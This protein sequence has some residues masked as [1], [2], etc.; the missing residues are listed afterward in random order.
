MY[1]YKRTLHV[2]DF[3][4][5]QTNIVSLFFSQQR[6]LIAFTVKPVLVNFSK[7]FYKSKSEKENVEMEKVAF[8]SALSL[9]YSDLTAEERFLN[10]SAKRR[11]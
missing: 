5:F 9:M 10:Q 11:V 6:A 3:I 1:I 7:K 8:P 2:T 4:L